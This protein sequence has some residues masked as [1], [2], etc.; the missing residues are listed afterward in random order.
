MAPLAYEAEVFQTVIATF[1]DV[2]FV[3]NVEVPPLDPG[4]RIFINAYI[5]RTCSVTS[6]TFEF[7]SSVDVEPSHIPIWWVSWLVEAVCWLVIR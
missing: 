6:I 7:V 5:H 4:I 3:V 1:G 2:P